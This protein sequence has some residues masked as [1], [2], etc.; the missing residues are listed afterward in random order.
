MMSTSPWRGITSGWL[1]PRSFNVNGIPTL[2][3]S[4]LYTRY[5]NHHLSVAGPACSGLGYMAITTLMLSFLP[6]S[7]IVQLGLPS[8]RVIKRA[9][10][11]PSVSVR[12]SVFVL[13][14]AGSLE[15]IWSIM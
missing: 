9:S 2:V 4:R 1:L 7:M 3:P 13:E 14:R 11:F 12:I 5:N 8:P 10:S 6:L 15:R